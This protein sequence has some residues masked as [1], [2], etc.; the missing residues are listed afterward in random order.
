MATESSISYALTQSVRNIQ[1]Q[2]GEVRTVPSGTSRSTIVVPS[3]ALPST[4]TRKSRVQY[5]AFQVWRKV[6][7]CL[8]RDT[9][10]NQ[11][12]RAGSVCG[13]AIHAGRRASSIDPILVAHLIVSGMMK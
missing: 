3:L 11:P 2:T 6:L 13:S 4:Q 10:P 1:I 8:A 7:E 5:V 12:V 9:L